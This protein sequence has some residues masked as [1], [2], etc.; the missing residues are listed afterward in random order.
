MTF[1]DLATYFEKQYLIP[2]EYVD[3]R[4]G[5]RGQEH[6]AGHGGDKGP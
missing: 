3:G 5:C 4:R 6:L 1:F 2:A